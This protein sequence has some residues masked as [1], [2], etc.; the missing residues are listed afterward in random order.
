MRFGHENGMDEAA[1]KII[2]KDTLKALEYF[3]AN[4]HVHR[5][6]KAGNIVISETGKCTA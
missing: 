2:L 1:I 3:H 5:D 4:G 6:I